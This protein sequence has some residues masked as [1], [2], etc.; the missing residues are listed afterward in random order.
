MALLLF[1]SL[2]RFSWITT[3]A[4]VLLLSNAFAQ[5]N[6]CMKPNSVRL[7]PNA[8]FQPNWYAPNASGV[9]TQITAGMTWTSSNP[10]VV[11]VNTSGVFAATSNLGEATITASWNGLT[12]QTKV[13]VVTDFV[14]TPAEKR[15]VKVAM[16]I[17][18]PQIP[19]AGNKRFSETFWAGNGGPM[20]LAKQTRDSIFSISG[21]T[22]DYQFT[23]IHQE[24]T[25]LN[26]FGGSTLSVDSM[27]RLFLEPGWTTLHRVAEQLGQS[28]FLYND[29]LN[30]Y[31]LCNKSNSH[32]VDEVWVWAMPFIGMWE[33]NMTGTGAFWINGAVVTGNSCTDLLPIMGFNYERYAGCSLHNFS[34]RIETTMYKLFNTGVR[35]APTDPPYPAGVP[36]NALQ[37]FML[38]DALEAGNAHVGNGHFPPNGTEGYDYDNM[39]NVLSRAPNWKRYPYIFDQTKSI[40]CTEWGCEGDCG[41]N[42]MSYWMRHIPH[43]KCKDKTGLLNNWWTYV[44]DYNE[45]KALEA[46]TDNCNCKMFAD[47]VVATCDHKG[48]AGAH[49]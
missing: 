6:L 33:S 13:K 35:Y 27:Y 41:L 28:E 2:S 42:F 37:T 23:E 30:K 29:M 9:E 12:Y 1:K 39:T 3:A 15:V 45:G 20:A 22:I 38:Y 31:D 34:H 49:G 5:S 21:G 10:S 4:F 11:S 24:P 26:K 17:I 48:T 14:A 18:D 16:I 36:K 44:I 43:F 25:F 40:N 46:Q 7:I 19:A 47:D 8:S 32:Q